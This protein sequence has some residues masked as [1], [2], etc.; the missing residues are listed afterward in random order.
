MPPLILSVGILRIAVAYV[1]DLKK[2]GLLWYYRRI[3]K[4]LQ[5]HYDGKPTRRVSLGTRDHVEAIRKASALAA[6]DDARWKSLRSPDGQAAELTLPETESAASATLASLGLRPGMLAKGVRRDFDLDPADILDDYFAKRHGKP[7]LEARHSE[8]PWDDPEDHLNAVDREMLRQLRDPLGTAGNVARTR[9]SA[10]RDIYLKQHDKGSDRQFIAHTN[11]ALGH[12]FEFVGDL[13]LASYTRDHANL[14]RDKLLASGLKTTSV[15]RR[16][17]SIK[18][19]FNEGINEFHLASV[20]NPFIKLKI[21]GEGHDAGKREPFALEQLKAIAKAC[22]ERPDDIRQIVAMQ[23]DTGARF[24]EIVALRTQDVILSGDVPHIH[25]R[26]HVALGRTIKTTNSD[27]KVPL[28]GEALWAA[29]LALKATTSDPKATGWLFSRY[30]ADR[31]ARTN[32]ANQT[33]NKWLRG[34]PGVTQTTHSFRHTMRD[35]LRH[36]DV[37]EE[38]QNLLGGWQSKSVGQR[39]GSGY[40][41]EQLHR[42]MLKVVLD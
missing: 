39:Y 15:R 23:L 38:F 26:P 6:Q 5:H 4:D 12:V 7:Y 33:I 3:P 19:V 22:R 24:S 9:L 16:F 28:V 11:R 40:A 37:K 8:E 20:R 42:E 31:D 17:N 2:D 21:A 41:L 10:A 32:S 34:L 35:R 27:R 36:A 18:A 30:V 25:I 14:I 13:P 1:S 29:R